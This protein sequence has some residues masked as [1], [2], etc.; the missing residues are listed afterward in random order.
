MVVVAAFRVV[1]NITFIHLK[2]H[3]RLTK[4]KEEDAQYFEQCHFG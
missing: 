4:N 2:V 3:T 1:K